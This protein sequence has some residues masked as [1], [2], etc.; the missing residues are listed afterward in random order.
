MAR[1]EWGE[2]LVDDTPTQ[3][4]K[5]PVESGGVYSAIETVDAKIQKGLNTTQTNSQAYSLV[6]TLKVTGGNHR[7]IMGFELFCCKECANPIRMHGAF[8][9]QADNNL[10][11]SYSIESS[12]NSEL[13]RYKLAWRF[14]DDHTSNNPKIEIWLIDTI[15]TGSFTRRCGCNV[16]MVEGIE[17]IN[18]N[19]TTNTLP[20]G[21]TDFTP[22][23]PLGETVNVDRSDINTDTSGFAFVN[24]HVY[25]LTAWLRGSGFSINTSSS[26]RGSIIAYIGSSASNKHYSCTQMVNIQQGVI[27]TD[28]IRL[29]VDW[30]AENIAGSSDNKLHIKVM[31]NGT[32]YSLVQSNFDLVL[33]GTDFD[34]A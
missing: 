27:T 1:R 7:G 24:G 14:A 23:Y 30:K 8:G 17:W 18:G 28:D 3:N 9:Y 19:S 33:V 25:H 10:S 13:A 5:N 4:S 32:E 21:L 15:N 20:S 2:F 16:H 11:A 22:F 34:G 6:G 26:G 12:V 31:F 29:H